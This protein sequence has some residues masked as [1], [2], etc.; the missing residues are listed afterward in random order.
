MKRDLTVSIVTVCYNSMKTIEDTLTSV[1]GQTY[2]HIQHI[3]VDGNSSDG[4][5]D[6]IQRYAEAAT[7]PVKWISEPDQ[8]IYDALNKGI[9]MADGEIIGILHSDDLLANPTVIERIVEQFEQDGSD[10]IY[11]DLAFVDKDNIRQ[12]KRLWIAGQG[13]FAL[14][15]SIPHQT[16]YLKREVYQSFGLYLTHM[17]NAADNEFILRVCKD[18]KINTSYINDVLVIMKLGGAST[19]NLSSS[20]KGFAEV[21]ESYRLH[22]IRFPRVVNWIRLL[23]KGKQVIAARWSGYKIEL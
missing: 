12:V 23:G 19:K 16:L 22:G 9:T 6:R 2:P 3:L 21:Q 14:G 5:Q 11:G 20:R 13:R 10:G 7:Y 17:S 1:H 8:G 4:T 15:W 18:G